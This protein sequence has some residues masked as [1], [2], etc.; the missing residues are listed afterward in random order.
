[1]DGWPLSPLTQQS[2]T[3]LSLTMDLY[4]TIHNSGSCCCSAKHTPSGS[5]ANTHLCRTLLE[6]CRRQLLTLVVNLSTTGRHTEFVNGRC[7]SLSVDPVDRLW[8][9]LTVCGPC[10]RLL[11]VCGLFRCLSMSVDVCRCLSL[12]VCPCRRLSLCVSYMS[13]SLHHA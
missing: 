5:D 7:L 8:T 9:L 6:H 13:A 1:M 10:R 4:L 2:L 11:T 3:T 12:S